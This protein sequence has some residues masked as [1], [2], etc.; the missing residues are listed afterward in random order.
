MGIVT[1]KKSVPKGVKAPF[2]A[3][4]EPML[5]QLGDA[6]PTDKN[7]LHEVKLDGY[8]ITAYLRNEVLLKSRSGEN[9]TGRYEPVA[10]ALQ[11]LKGDMVLDG[12]VVVVNDDGKHDF[13]LLQNYQRTH[14]GHVI[15]YVFDLLWLN[16]YDLMKLPLTERKEIL[17]NTIESND[18]AK[19]VDVFEDGETLF[20]QC[21]TFGFE[22]I[23]SKKK[24][25]PIFPGIAAGTG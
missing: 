11:K 25:A 21:P 10:E 7:Y 4:V 19:V 22:G 2:P 18:V 24:T 6:V 16:G 3:R 9:Y 17:N 13:T 14:E 5:C 15:Y 1:R 12:E 20:E 8:R 23:V